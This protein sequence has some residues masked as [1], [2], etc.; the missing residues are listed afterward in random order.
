MGPL[1]SAENEG[2]N[3]KTHNYVTISSVFAFKLKHRH[4]KL[5]LVEL[6]V[7]SRAVEPAPSVE[8]KGSF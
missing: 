8:V 6:N 4:F 3:P 5:D 1:Y 7:P 2:G